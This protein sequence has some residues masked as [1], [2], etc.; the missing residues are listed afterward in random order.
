MY[1]LNSIFILFLLN[2]IYININVNS[3]VILSKYMKPNSIISNY[4]K[5]N[6][7]IIVLDTCFLNTNKQNNLM[8]LFQ[9]INSYQKLMRTNN[10]FPTFLLN[11][12]SG[13][14]TIPSYKL[15]LNKKFWIFA[16]ITQLTMLDSMVIND[17][18]DL[19]IDLINNN[20][21]PLVNK[22][23]TLRE[24][25][26]L[27][28][29]IQLITMLLSIIFLRNNNIF[30][31]IYSIN[32]ILF[33]YT[34]FLKKILF[35]KNITCSSVVASTIYLTSKTMLSVPSNILNPNMDLINIT[36][37]FLF[38]SSLYI[39]LLQDIKDIKG[40]KANNIITIPNFFGV[41]KTLD[42]LL[43]LF[44]VNVI[45]YSSNFIRNKNTTLIT[46][47]L[48]SNII[49]F[50]NLIQLRFKN[51]SNENINISLKHTTYSLII[52]IITIMISNKNI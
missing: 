18:F 16:L 22:Q 2:N 11:L 43:V 4:P 12:L 25:K 3:F 10:V 44:S 34:P 47:F 15:F 36:T 35:I 51:H 45:Y 49:F 37:K 24:A 40:D 27:Y 28:I 42:L 13:W 14:I 6:N 32:L 29:S 46:G 5:K 7:Q 30:L 31:Y 23:I 21:R 8:P 20:N 38:L 33:L 9:K 1:F 26:C 41:K 17:L 39:E 50:K 19:K 48:I 52:F